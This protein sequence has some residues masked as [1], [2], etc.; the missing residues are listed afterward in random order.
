MQAVLKYDPHN[1]DSSDPGV[2]VMR[3]EK[4]LSMDSNSSQNEQQVIY[5]YFG[6]WCARSHFQYSG[7]G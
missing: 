5:G 3:N 6:D 7:P 1:Q 4:T 2:D